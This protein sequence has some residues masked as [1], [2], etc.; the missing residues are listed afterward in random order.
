MPL[1]LAIDAGGT[2][3][4]YVL[5]DDTTVLARTR[6]GTIKRLRTSAETATDNLNTA[7]AALTQQSG[8]SLQ[9]VA[10]TVIGTAGESVPLVADFLRQQFAARVSGSLLLVGDVEIALDAAFHGG[11]GV[12]ALAGT[13]SNVAGRDSTGKLYNRGGWGPALADQGSGYRIG[14]TALRAVFLAID[15]RRDSTLQQA[16]LD[17][18]QLPS[19][20]ALIEHSNS[21]PAPDFSRLVHIVLQVAEAGDPLAQEILA[22]QGE[23][24]AYLVRL[25]LRAMPA[26]TPQLA[27]AGSILEHVAPVRKALLQAV[28][29]E[30]PAVT[31]LPGVVDPIEGALW[32]AR[33]EAAFHARL[34]STKS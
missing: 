20:A 12:L 19:L 11:P 26:T 3:T 28:Q 24:L 8:T 14:H 25:L 16:I 31:M 27:C 15:E 4:D 33:D 2:K 18:W 34:H 6:S 29:S 23:E 10:R 32:R 9:H 7:L 17:H 5:A 1:Y 30:F 13:G 22:R 21:T